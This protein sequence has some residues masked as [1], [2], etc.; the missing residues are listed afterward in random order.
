MIA[1]SANCPEEVL[2]KKH[3][4]DLGILKSG[5]V[6]DD[7]YLAGGTGAALTLKHRQSLDLDFFSDKNFNPDL[8]ASR[9]AELGHLELERKE[10]GTVTGLFNNTR[11]SL[12]YYPYPLLRA[13]QTVCGISVAHVIDIACMKIDAIASRGS[14]KDFID[15]YTIA[16]SGYSLK[17][18]LGF[19]QEKYQ[20][21]DY[22]LI[23]IQKGLV[24]FNDAEK[25][26]EPI[27]LQPMNW[28]KVKDFFKREANDM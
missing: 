3:Q 1:M 7:F 24:Y 6:L 4:H 11:L 28:E 12:F 23:H 26:P 20:K 14:K 21:L 17:D 16:Q 15:L 25:D 22:N 8:I 5:Q 19:F 27:M 10:Q 9:I 2:D 13:T 18:L